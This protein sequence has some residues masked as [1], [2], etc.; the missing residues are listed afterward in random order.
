M[1]ELC[2]SFDELTVGIIKNLPY[3]VDCESTNFNKFVILHIFILT[4]NMPYKGD[5]T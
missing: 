3:K 4:T 2:L 5:F 1:A